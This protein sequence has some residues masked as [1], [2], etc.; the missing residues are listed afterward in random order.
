MAQGNGYP[1]S[2]EDLGGGYRVCETAS[3][4]SREVALREIRAGGVGG[5]AVRRETVVREGAAL[6]GRPDPLL[7]FG[8]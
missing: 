6:R 5:L 3:C 2:G 7:A 4:R 1:P 8:K